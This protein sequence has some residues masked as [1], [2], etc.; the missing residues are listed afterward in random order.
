[1]IMAPMLPIAIVVVLL[2][3][4]PSDAS[5]QAVSPPAPA[6]PF[7]LPT[8]VVTAQKEPADV[9]TLPVSVTV[10]GP[11]TLWNTGATIVSD[12]SIFS[13]NTYFNEFS[14]R[15]LS[16]A[17]MRGVGSS[18]ANPGVT[19]YIDGVPQL[20]ANASS[21]DLLDVGQVEFARGPQ[22]ALFGR[23]V[24]GGLVNVAS[25]RPSLSGWTGSA[26]V[27]LGNASTREVRAGASGPLVS[28]RLG[29]AASMAYG[30]R[31]GFT[32]NDITGHTLDDRSAFSGKAQ[33]LW[34]PA[35]LWEARAIVSGERARDGDYALHDLG[36]L[37]QNPF[38]AARDFEGFTH[39]DI[40]NTTVLARREGARVAFST[41]TGFVRWKTEDATD[42]DYSPLPLVTRENAEDAFQF[43]QEVRFA[44]AA[45]APVR[46]SDAV[47][48]RWQSGLFLFTQDYDQDAVNRF[49]PF[50]LSPFLGFPVSQASPQAA[51]NDVGLGLYGQ[52]TATLRDR[53]DVTAGA[54]FDHESKE[55]EL[56]TFY[57]PA[58]APS[59]NVSAEQSFSNVSPQLAVAF[60]PAADRTLYAAVSR[61]FKA[62]GFN[63]A[64]PVGSEAYDEEHTWHVEGGVKG[65]WGGRVSASA[66][67]FFIDWDD[68][69]LNLPDPA[70]PAQFY[71]AN[72]G[73]ATSTGVEAEV[74]ARVT[75]TGAGSSVASG[76]S[77][78]IDVDVFGAIG[79]THARFG[80]DS[81]SSGI[82]VAGKEL[83][84]APEYTATFGA[85][86][87]HALRESV[88]LYGRAEAV[89]YGAYFYDDANTASQDAYSLVNFRAGARGRRLFAEAWVKN[90][91]DTEYIPVAFAY[92]PFAPSGFVGEMGRPRTFGLRAG[93]TF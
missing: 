56:S 65:S 25:V 91:F 67:V 74:N 2:L 69:Q 13:P 79:Y 6:G 1:S 19:T 87:A 54:R 36:A 85:Q 12:A 4:A 49:A 7:Q 26:Y 88:A 41:T 82:P 32:R 75:P 84:N 78:K 20:N 90:A 8:V 86:L 64:A 31:D 66:A 42:L 80:D 43:T 23:N 72:V 30:Q 59:T 58:V 29:L 48:L 73:S 28:G 40:V 22:S 14:A 16:N 77:R 38:H 15:K 71:I 51:L 39:R 18:P 33:L 27:P 60:R 5:A 37:R 70:V 52:A 57:A 62:G 68:L 63:P 89:F 24:L 93:V 35:A 50:L 21:I 11:E 46:L 10:V 45:N 53:V 9:R 81:I 47:A 3:L 44:S 76:F 55:G 92:G 34:T 17:R 61:G 83:P